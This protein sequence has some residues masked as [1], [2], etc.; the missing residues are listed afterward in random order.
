MTTKNFNVKNG[1]TTGNIVLDAATGNIT[2]LGNANL[3]NLAIANFFSGNGNA[4]FNIQGANVVGTVANA[5]TAVTAGTVTTN[6]Q[7][8]ITSVGTLTGLVVGNATANV[9]YNNDGNGSLSATGN[10]TA[11]NF[12]GNVIGNISGNI[13]VPGSNT[14]VLFND[15]GNANSS[16]AFTFDKVS[17]VVSIAGNANIGNIGTGGLVTATGNILVVM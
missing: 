5:T 16:T 1:I 4:L 10:I 17:N 14:G 15:N 12:I 7:P 9:T 6:A 11:A 13:I 8:N 3:G 2:G